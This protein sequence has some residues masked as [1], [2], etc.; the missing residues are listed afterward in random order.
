M[1]RPSAFRNPNYS[2]LSQFD[3]MKLYVD[4]LKKNN[5]VAEVPPK[6]CHPDMVRILQY[7][8]N[9]L[10][11]PANMAPSVEEVAA[12]ILK[13]DPDVI[14][15]QECSSVCAT[16][17]S[18]TPIGKL[19]L[20]QLSMDP[21]TDALLRML[22]EK[23]I[24]TWIDS[25]V[26][27]PTVIGT[28]LKHQMLDQT[29]ISPYDS[30]DQRGAAAIR[31]E[32]A[33]GKLLLFYGAH[34]N[35][36]DRPV[37]RRKAESQQILEHIHNQQHVGAVVV[38]ADFNEQRPQHYA[39]EERDLINASKK[40]RN[41]TT[42]EDLVGKTFENEGFVCSFDA[43]GAKHNWQQPEGV[44]RPPM[45]HW[46]GTAIDYSYGKGI[47]C[48]GVYVDHSSHASDHTPVITDWLLH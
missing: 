26:A 35:H 27:F 31:V 42:L 7:N 29:T 44:S 24:T 5:M 17:S 12:I 8:I 43:T 33:S 32:T 1:S 47:T 41:S 4:D 40:R 16:S 39:D 36:L 18:D 30:Y 15:L 34:L 10:R 11:G 38:A 45:T 25:G 9:T 28:R 19:S 22:H 20:S 46:T 6:P 37:G 14:A 2:K 13:H 3:L 21:R 23:G 48:D